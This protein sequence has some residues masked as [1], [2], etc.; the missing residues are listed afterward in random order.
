MNIRPYSEQDRKA[1]LAILD[2]NTPEFFIA[3]DHHSLDHFLSHL[4]GPYFVGEAQGTIIACG[5]WALGSDGMA[6]L[7]WG[8]VGRAFHRRGL[9]RRL[10]RFRLEAIRNDTQAKV[11][12]IHTVQ[13][14]QAFF[15]K[16]GFTVID[17]VPNG[18]GPGLDRVTMELRLRADA[19]LRP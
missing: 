2:E 6:V 5:G 15:A 7:T 14:V 9:G 13:L 16:E 12:R 3:E 17:T 19:Q 10:L 1:C 8:M 18:F 11:A 4:P